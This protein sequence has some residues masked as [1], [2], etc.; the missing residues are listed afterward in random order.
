MRRSLASLSVWNWCSSNLSVS[1][2]RQPA[3]G[4]RLCWSCTDTMA[5][6]PPWQSGLIDREQGVSKA[7]NPRLRATLVELAWLWV[8]HQPNSVLTHWFLDR[9]KA[10]GGRL[11]KLTIVALARKL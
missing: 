3:A 10:N 4:G 5:K 11:R 9:V 1:A 6:R 7:G 2:L 8:R